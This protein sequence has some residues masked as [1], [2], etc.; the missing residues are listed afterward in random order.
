MPACPGVGW[1]AEGQDF[2]A[3]EEPGE[4]PGEP[5]G[6]LPGMEEE[7]AVKVGQRG[8]RQRKDCPDGDHGHRRRCRPCARY[9]LRILTLPAPARF[10]PPDRRWW[11]ACGRRFRGR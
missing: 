10:P 8:Q 3:D 2:I 5:E 4:E 1:E 6:P 9:W 7:D 11:C